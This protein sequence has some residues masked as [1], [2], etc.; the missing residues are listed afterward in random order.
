MEIVDYLRVARRR[1]WLLVGVPV[2]AAGAAATLV[3]IAPQQY[4]ATAYVAAPALVGG[5]AAQQY[6]GNQA[7]NQ[8]AAAFS[9]AATSPRVVDEVA[10]DTGIAA[11]R[12]RSGLSVSQVGASSQM[13]ITYAST[14]RATVE[15]VLVA[16]A[17][18][19]LAFLFSSQV[20][21]ATEQVTAASADVTAATAAITAW[22]TE[23]EVTQPDKIYQATLS[24][25]ASLRQ[26]RLQMQAVGNGRGVDAATEAIE[27]GQRRLDTIGPKLPD[28]EALIAQRDA[29]T[30]ALSSARQ[31]LQ[32]A[33]AQAQAAD[34]AEVASVG[35]VRAV[36][37]TRALVNATVPVAGAGVLLA[38]VLV[39]LLELLARNRETEPPATPSGDP[40]GPSGPRPTG[41]DETREIPVARVG[42]ATPVGQASR[43]GGR[44]YGSGGALEPH[45]GR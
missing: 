7:A 18:R 44:V 16:T 32:A 40:V 12:L 38:V 24:E 28:Y 20:A 34:P 21:I 1:L 36:S 29:A 17:D 4:T 27:A 25:L 22:E 8:F 19:A 30:S 2:L 39:A 33:R 26:Q 23:N 31:G 13:E 37:R 45:A 35:A 43:T 5:A 6:T 3:L 14:N 10:A 15:P 41:G 9:A 11:S 42:R